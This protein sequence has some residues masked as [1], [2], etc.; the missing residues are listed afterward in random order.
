MQQLQAPVEPHHLRQRGPGRAERRGED[1][2]GVTRLVG[3]NHREGAGAG[4]GVAGQAGEVGVVGD[5]VS[6]IQTNFCGGCVENSG[7]RNLFFE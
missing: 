3:Q 4:R 5:L 1:P 2:V 6:C 7:A